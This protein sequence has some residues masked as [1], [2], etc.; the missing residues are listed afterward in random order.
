MVLKYSGLTDVGNIRELNED[1]FI[2]KRIGEHEYIF[3]VADGMGG[4]KAGE[5]ASYKAVNSFSK[6]IS[7]ERKDSNI[8]KLLKNT[9]FKVNQLI[10]RE[11]E[12]YPDRAGMGTTLSALYIMRKYA[13]IVHVGDSR[14]YRISKSKFEQ[15]TEDHSTVN[16]MVKNGEITK[17]E[18]RT[19]P[20]RHEITQS[21]GVFHE[22]EID[23]LGPMKLQDGDKFLLCSDGVTD[24]LSDEVIKKEL[25]KRTAPESI[26]KSIISMVKKKGA[27]D[28]ITT[29]IIEVEDTISSSESNVYHYILD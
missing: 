8:I 9:A 25:E 13:F 19:H 26:C 21:M 29:I 11:G 4:H 2:T 7:N 6:M 17:E 24:T 27:P 15:V 5:I 20:K 28:N 14:I 18:A 16:K 3:I 23:T 1:N 10:V 22:I 12:I